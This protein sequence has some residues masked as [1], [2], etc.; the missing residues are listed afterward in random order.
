MN[1]KSTII[2]SLYCFDHFQIPMSLKLHFQISLLND[3]GGCAI[4][5]IFE[6][7]QTCV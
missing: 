5:L 4:C 1:L 2:N 7:A 6:W 3:C